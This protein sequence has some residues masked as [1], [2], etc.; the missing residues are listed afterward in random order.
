MVFKIS[1]SH[2][3]SDYLQ[4]FEI[5]STITLLNHNGSE[6]VQHGT[7][8]DW[9]EGVPLFQSRMIL[10]TCR[11]IYFEARSMDNLSSTLRIRD[12]KDLENIRNM[13]LEDAVAIQDLIIVE[14]PTITRSQ[15]I[16]K[17]IVKEFWHTRW[18]MWTLTPKNVTIR[19]RDS[20]P[21]ESTNPVMA[22]REIITDVIEA[23]QKSVTHLIVEFSLDTS[24]HKSVRWELF[25][26]VI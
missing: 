20:F 9:F 24:S 11:R 15:I 6:P 4:R 8:V 16:Q 1:F 21:I 17:T 19:F 13:R 2:L 23:C 7:M 25:Q 12:K 3:S 14:T 26:I 22:I 10:A 18:R 5:W